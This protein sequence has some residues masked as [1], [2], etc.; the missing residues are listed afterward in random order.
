MK[1]ATGKIFMSGRSQAVRIPKEF[2]FDATEVEFLRTPY[3]IALRPVMAERPRLTPAEAMAKIRAL[4]AEGGPVDF[5]PRDQP[6]D[7]MRDYFADWKD[8]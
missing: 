3:G 8:E 7:P 6:A 1:P 2:R 5:P 4:I